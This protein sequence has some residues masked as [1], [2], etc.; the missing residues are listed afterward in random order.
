MADSDEANI[1]PS[2][3]L[4]Y[5]DLTGPAAIIDA[6]RCNQRRPTSEWIRNNGR[7]RSLICLSMW[8]S[9]R[10]RRASPSQLH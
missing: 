5:N 7:A 1:R 4:R 2:G 3:L 10:I 9:L 6:G 8:W